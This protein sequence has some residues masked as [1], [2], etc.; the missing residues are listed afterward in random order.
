LVKISKIPQKINLF[1]EYSGCGVYN[2]M[3]IP[4]IK[5]NKLTR[6][7][8][9]NKLLTLVFGDIKLYSKVYPHVLKIQK[10]INMTLKNLGFR[11][12]RI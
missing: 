4:G 9:R 8:I 7:N 3:H 1:N 5:L 12:I 10:G 11:M 6:I 2:V